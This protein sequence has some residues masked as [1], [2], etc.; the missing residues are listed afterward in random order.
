MLI[1]SGTEMLI[2]HC[3][4]SRFG[5][6]I[7]GACRLL[8]NEVGAQVGSFQMHFEW[9][10]PKLGLMFS[11]VQGQILPVDPKM[12]EGQSIKM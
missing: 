7:K 10:F 4:P 6:Q 8:L 12:E 11:A 2:G 9:I 5:N 1:H 3:Y